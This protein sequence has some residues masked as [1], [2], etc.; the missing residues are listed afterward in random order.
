MNLQISN[1]PLQWAPNQGVQI[2]FFVEQENQEID[3]FDAIAN[4]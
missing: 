2:E 3:S 4:W 1:W